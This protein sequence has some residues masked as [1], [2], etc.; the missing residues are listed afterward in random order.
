MSAKRA[1]VRAGGVVVGS[2]DKEPSLRV[3]TA[4][5][6]GGYRVF[7]APV[8][9]KHTTRERIAEAVIASRRLTEAVRAQVP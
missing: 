8:E 6:P 3:R 9:P 1:A 7:G 5:L 2:G 4:L